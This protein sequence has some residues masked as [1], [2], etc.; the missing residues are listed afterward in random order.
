MS[1]CS[2]GGTFLASPSGVGCGE[3]T[4]V[5]KETQVGQV[6]TRPWK[7]PFGTLESLEVSRWWIENLRM[8]PMIFLAIKI[9]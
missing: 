2:A 8:F 5:E 1:I 7:S 6:E 9:Q 3:A 4:K